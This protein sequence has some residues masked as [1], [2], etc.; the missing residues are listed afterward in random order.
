MR[1][2]HPKAVP[3]SGAE[4]K[5]C[6]G[7]RIGD[8]KKRSAFAWDKS[9]IGGISTTG[10]QK[11]WVLQGMTS[12]NSNSFGAKQKKINCL[13]LN[14]DCTTKISCQNL[15]SLIGFINSRETTK[16]EFANDCRG[17]NELLLVSVIGFMV[18]LLLTRSDSHWLNGPFHRSQ[19]F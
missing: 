9:G 13:L 2:C 1:R 10:R 11:C 19:S 16:C 7:R 17:E 6:D 3:G 5:G 4:L 14:Y 8:E 15:F 18:I 12:T